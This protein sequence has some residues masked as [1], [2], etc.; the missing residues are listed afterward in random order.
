MTTQELQALLSQLQTQQNASLT[1]LGNSL[2][3]QLKGQEARLEASFD[4]K[5]RTQISEFRVELH[6]QLAS[7]HQQLRTVSEDV[8]QLKED[9]ADS[10]RDLGTL[11]LRVSSLEAR[12]ELDLDRALFDGDTLRTPG[13]GRRVSAPQRQLELRGARLIYRGGS[14]MDPDLD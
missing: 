2:G 6:Q 13:L 10:R 12:E 5:V 8:A 4:A 11:G 7:L 3:E 14:P 9:V 1:S